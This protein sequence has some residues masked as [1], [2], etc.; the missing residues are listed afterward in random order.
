VIGVA[1]KASLYAVKVLNGQGGGLLSSVLAGMTWALQNNMKVVSMSLGASSGPIVAYENAIAQL[2]RAGVNV[3]CASGNAFGG[4]FPWV[5]A[6]ANSHPAAIAVGAV[7]SAKVIAP[8]SSRGING[9]NWNGVTLSAPGVSVN[10]TWPVPADGYRKLS[11]TSM[12]CPHV[13]GA[14][15]LVCQK[16]PNLNPQQI[17][18]RLISTASDLG[19]PGLD[20]TYGA[21]LVNCDLLTQ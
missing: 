12:A 6:P 15:A 3:V 11:G 10:S 5:G 2:T 4:P 21:G 17:K 7:D 1:P 9:A 14:V 16:F 19:V 20:S 18:A 13:S 8:F